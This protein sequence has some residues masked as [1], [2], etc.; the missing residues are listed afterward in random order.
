MLVD[1][2][3][4]SPYEGDTLLT[5]NPIGLEPSTHV[6]T[7]PFSE[8]WKGLVDVRTVRIVM[9]DI[10]RADGTVWSFNVYVDDKGFVLDRSERSPYEGDTLLTTNPIGL[11]PSTHVVTTPFSEGWKGLVDVRTVRIVMSDIP[12]AVMFLYFRVSTVT[13]LIINEI[14]IDCCPAIEQQEVQQPDSSQN[15]LN[16]AICE[17]QDFFRT[18]VPL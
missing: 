14:I 15:N 6:V 12:R 4:R 11:E 5:T 16:V 7:T 1:R 17:N 18:R 8:G 9:S 10:P 3:E 13:D 2:S